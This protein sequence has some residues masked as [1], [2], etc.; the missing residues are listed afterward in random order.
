MKVFKF[1]GASVKDA[2]AVKNVASIIKNYGNDKL[3]VVVSAMGKTTNA[4][5]KVVNAHY[6]NKNADAHKFLDEI[7]AY[8]NEIMQKLF[9]P[10]D[11][12]Y[13]QVNNFFVEIDWVL[14]EPPRSYPFIYD[15]VVAIGELISTKIVSAHLNNEGLKNAW[16]DARSCIKT[17][18]TYRS[19]NID[20]TATA[21]C[22]NNVIDNALS[23]ADIVM[24]QGFIGGTSENYTTT[25]GREGSDYSAAVFA[26]CLNAE[27][28]TIWKDVA[29]VL[30]ADPKFF[31]DAQKMEQINYLDAI[32]LAYYGASV[33]HPKT[34]KPLENKGIPLYVKSFLKPDSPGTVIAKDLQTK[35]FI[36]SYI[37]KSDQVL[38]SLAAKDFSFITEEGLSKIFAMIAQ[39]G[40]KVNM[41]QNSAIS[42]SLCADNDPVLIHELIEE[43]K[44][45]YRVLYNDNLLLY[46]VR[47]YNQ[48]TL[49]KLVRDKE[50]LVEQ[51]S[52]NTV[53]LVVREINAG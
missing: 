35:P 34:I 36:P 26:H 37:F 41:M 43:L 46:T 2:D 7:K 18:N 49:E 32:E 39:A 53:Q 47:H 40:V 6:N 19:A 45:S 11:D 44:K 50:V 23:G 52:R 14:E 20:W 48:F 24:V 51:R 16:T 29:G 30:N 3:V 9:S 33:I 15:Q 31:E 28:L 38:I 5:E 12:V 10:G 8:H 1:G 4:L 13:A 22:I 21:K 17:D 27:S 42:F 25:L